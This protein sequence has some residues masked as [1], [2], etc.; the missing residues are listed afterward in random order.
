MTTPAQHSPAAPRSGPR[1]YART[2]W[3]LAALAFAIDAALVTLFAALGRSSHAR[4]ATL[5]GLWQ[6]AWPFLCALALIWISAR[7]SKRPFA[8]IKSGLSVWF[9]TAAVGLLLRGL[10]GGGVAFPFV[11]VT[12]GALGVFLVG[13]RIIAQLILRI[14]ARPR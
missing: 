1:E 10:T 5:L 3:R 12:L 8:P 13:W 4:E 7:V 6:T 11:L 9:G 14:A 2:H